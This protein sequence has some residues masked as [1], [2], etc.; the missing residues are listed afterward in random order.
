MSRAASVSWGESALGGA[1]ATTGSASSR[2]ARRQTIARGLITASYF[3]FRRPFE[4]IF[5]VAEEHVEGG[6]R[7]VTAGDVLLQ[8]ELVFGFE[9]GVTIDLLLE[10]P[11]PVAQHHDLV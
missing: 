10:D 11:Q 6:Q 4:V 1:M 5:L 9:L 7:A 8:V 3:V 2:P